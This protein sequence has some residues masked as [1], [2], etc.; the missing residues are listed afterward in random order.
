[1]EQPTYAKPSDKD[2]NKAVLV[3]KNPTRH[4]AWRKSKT[5]Y[6]TSFTRSKHQ[7]G[8]HPQYSNVVRVWASHLKSTVCIKKQV[9]AADAAVDTAQ[10]HEEAE[11][12]EV[13]VVKVTHAV[14]QPGWDADI[15][16]K[17][18]LFKVT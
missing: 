13:T 5:Q 8:Q 4:Q 11:G 3:R 2:R 10:G 6:Q 15:K 16:E 12:E 9:S 7:A 1:M 18:H 14:I 17:H